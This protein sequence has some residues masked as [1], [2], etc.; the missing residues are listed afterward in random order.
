MFRGVILIL[1]LLLWSKL[2]QAADVG[3]TNSY[4]S[5]MMGAID[6]IQ[7]ETPT[8]DWIAVV[9]GGIGISPK[10]IGSNKAELSAL[11]LVD[12]EWRQA[13]FFSTVRGAGLN[14]IRQP[15]LKAGAR[16]T[17]DAGRKAQ[18]NPFLTGLPDVDRSI[19]FGLFLESLVG[20]WRLRTDLRKGLVNSGHNGLVASF[21]L[22]IASKLSRVSNIVVGGVTHYADSK[23][24]K[25]YF[26][27]STSATGRT[28][29]TAD[30]GGF[31]DI[32]AYGTIVYNITNQMFIASTLRT[33]LLVGNA[34]DSSISQDDAQYFFGTIIG[35]R[36]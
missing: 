22:A 25:A 16:F 6:I 23:Y 31:T 9:G 13:Y 27:V 12:L 10:F 3:G 1:V 7:L 15:G 29:F 32:G 4:E 18:E 21:D 2:G 19:E 17:L 14:V 26:D 20:N 24:Q 33:S 30:G 5:Q 34:A 28:N 11:P 35:W 36:L 8:T